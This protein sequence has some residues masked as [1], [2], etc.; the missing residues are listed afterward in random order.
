MLQTERGVGP[1]L[2]QYV[3]TGWGW[4]EVFIYSKKTDRSH[5]PKYSVSASLFWIPV[6][7]WFW[8]CILVDWKTS[9]HLFLFSAGL[10]LSGW[11]WVSHTPQSRL[12]GRARLPVKH[13]H[14]GLSLSLTVSPHL[15]VV[16]PEVIIDGGGEVQQEVPGIFRNGSFMMF[17]QKCVPQRQEL[18]SN[19]D[20][21][22]VRQTFLSP[23][24]SSIIPSYLPAMTIFQ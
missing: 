3:V 12:S 13:W 1:D 11:R 6:E 23:P 22:R 7:I 2:I 9:L 21:A 16:V 10:N 18:E 17:L 4:R 19:K 20:T 24:P 8:F 5:K 14:E 15:L